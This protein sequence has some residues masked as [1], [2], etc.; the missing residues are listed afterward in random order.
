MVVIFSLITAMISIVLILLIWCWAMR[1][2]DKLRKEMLSY[3]YKNLRKQINP[4][5]LFNSLHTIPEMLT[6]DPDKTEIYIQKLIE[7]YHHILDSEDVDLMQLELELEFV[8][9]YFRLEKEQ[10]KEKQAFIAGTK[11]SEKY[12]IIPQSV[13]TLLKNVLQQFPSSAGESLLFSIK[14]KND[15]IVIS[16]RIKNR[17]SI[18]GSCQTKLLNLHER[19]RLVTGE[20]VLMY[21]ED[22]SFALRLPLIKV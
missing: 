9:Q 19:S 8:R 20:E 22:G 12:L 15:Y 7:I 10:E 18:D 6:I 13:Q 21:Y 17:N 1:R 16:D 3:K 2:E 14:M 5:F 4:T 11:E